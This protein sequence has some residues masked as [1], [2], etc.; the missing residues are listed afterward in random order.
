MKPDGKGGF[1]RVKKKGGKKKGG[2]KGG[3]NERK[4]GGPDGNM[5]DFSDSLLSTDSEDEPGGYNRPSSRP[6]VHST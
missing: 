5:T 4:G 3:K 2:K 6:A 1:I